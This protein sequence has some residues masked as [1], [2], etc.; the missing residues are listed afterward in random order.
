MDALRMAHGR[1]APRP[2]CITHSDRGSEYISAEFRCVIRELRLRQSRGRTGSYFD[3]AAAEGFRA[4]LETLGYLTPAEIGQR[5]QHALAT[6]ESSV[7]NHGKAS[8]NRGKIQSRRPPGKG[9][10]SLPREALPTVRAMG[11]TAQIIVRADSAHFSAKGPSSTPE[12]GR[13]RHPPP[14]DPHPGAHR[15]QRSPHHPPPALMPVRESGL[16][17]PVDRRRPPSAHLKRQW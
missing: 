12:R 14:P 1:A 16:R 7:Q 9:V 10:A 13:R 8:V 15:N 17:R 2:G 5:Q 11:I 4:L 3:N 6:Q